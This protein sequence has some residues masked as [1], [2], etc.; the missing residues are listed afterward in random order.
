MGRQNTPAGP[1]RPAGDAPLAALDDVARSRVASAAAAALAGNTRATYASQ[2]NRFAAWCEERGADPLAADPAQV[3]AYLAERAETRKLVDGAGLGGGD[4]GRRALGRAGGPDEDAAGRRHA[5]R[6]RAPARRRPRG[7]APPG[8]RPGLRDRARPDAGGR[9]APAPRPGAGVARGCRSPRPARRRDRGAGVLRRPAPLRD[10]RPGLGRHHADG[11]RRAAAGPRAGL[12]GQRRRPA[13]GPAAA[14][15]SL[16]PRRR[17]PAHGRG[18]R[19]GRA[20]RPARPAPSQPPPA[21]PGPKR[22]VSRA[23]RRTPDAGG[24]PRSWSAAA[25]RPPPCRP[26]A[27]GAAPRWSPATPRPSPSRTEPSPGSS[28]A[29]AD[30]RSSNGKSGSA[31]SREIPASGAQLG[32]HY[33]HDS[34]R[35]PPETRGRCGLPKIRY[36]TQGWELGR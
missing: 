18:A 3:A 24:W 19:R 31:A 7:G 1:G 6:H 23:S 12:E 26:P 16:R 14:R 13:R 25:P 34:A 20:R 17:G 2:W 22:S 33:N 28:G 35:K 29:E 30:R 27:A 5:A 9:A 10:R 4:R 32:A 21:G 15:R 8:R 11:A 36:R